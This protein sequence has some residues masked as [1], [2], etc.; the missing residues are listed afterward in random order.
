MIDY[1]KRCVVPMINVR[2]GEVEFEI[3][4][5]GLRARD[6]MT[7]PNDTIGSIAAR[8]PGHTS[9]PFHLYDL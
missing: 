3:I 2:T 7:V 9:S 4:V 8:H 1:R 5:Y 6:L